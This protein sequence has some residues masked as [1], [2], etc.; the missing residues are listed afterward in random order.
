MDR[1]V[2]FVELVGSRVDVVALLGGKPGRAQNEDIRRRS[3][4]HLLDQF[5]D[6]GSNVLF[7]CLSQWWFTFVFM[8]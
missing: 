1:A 8:F 5:E 3:L 2:L 7:S 4:L 6:S